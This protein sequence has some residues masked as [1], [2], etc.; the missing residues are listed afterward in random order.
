[1]HPDG[2]LATADEVPDDDD[3]TAV[4]AQ[5]D[6][7]AL[8]GTEGGEEKGDKSQLEG[9]TPTSGTV[10]VTVSVNE[11]AA[12]VTMDEMDSHAAVTSP[13]L[14]SSSPSEAAATTVPSLPS[15][16]VR[17][18]SLSSKSRKEIRHQVSDSPRF[19]PRILALTLTHLLLHGLSATAREGGSSGQ[20]PSYKQQKCQD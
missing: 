11:V 7:V 10:S 16:S 1:M 8:D 2:L 12:K 17:G 5:V 14:P 18:A 13:T 15:S 20:V 3:D 4:S 6:A 9:T 19:Y